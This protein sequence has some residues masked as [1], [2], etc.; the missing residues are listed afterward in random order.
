MAKI[1]YGVAGEGSGHSSRAKEVITHLLSQGHEVKIFSYHTGYKNLSK[2]FP[3]GRITGLKFDYRDNKVR[4]LQTIY[5]NALQLPAAKKSLSKILKTITT[6]KPEV[7]FSDFEP[8]TCIAANLKRLP[9]ISLDNQH[10]YTD[11]K[12]DYPLKHEAEAAVARAITKLV[13]FN[14]KEKLVLSFANLK[15]KNKKT[16]I[17][18]PVLRA[19]ILKAKP[20]VGNYILTYVTTPSEQLVEALHASEE[21]FVCYG[22]NKNERSKNITYKEFSFEGFRQDLLKCKGIIGNAGFTLSGEALHLGKPYLAWP[23]TSQFEQILNAHYI[24]KLGYGLH[25]ENLDSETIDQ[26]SKNI[27]KYQKKL[28]KYKQSDN[29]KLFNKVDSIVAQYSK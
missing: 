8:L 11:V 3:V 27:P 13:I 26:F 17:F 9:L 4:I 5:K 2:S 6:F 22:F 24:Q 12:I 18:P 19:D 14:A 10:L 25:A 21:K 1:I 16:F 15:P 20:S 29:Q 23:V 7:V 28:K